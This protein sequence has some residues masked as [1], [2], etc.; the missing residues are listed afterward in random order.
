MFQRMFQRTNFAQPADQE[1]QALAELKTLI[2]RAL[3]DSKIT[4][5][6]LREIHAA[7]LG[8]GKITNEECKLL[9]AMILEKVKLREIKL[10]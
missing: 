7:A 9:S 3:E 6:E 5:K 10:E 8:D 4:R 2:D 1:L